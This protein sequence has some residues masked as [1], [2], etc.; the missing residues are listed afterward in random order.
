M[1]S[2]AQLSAWTW[3]RRREARMNDALNA[4]GPFKQTTKDTYRHP[5]C[6]NYDG[7]LTFAAVRRWETFSCLGCR[8]AHGTWH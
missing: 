4:V 2:T 8:K 7:C 3:V 5:D 1:R 6:A